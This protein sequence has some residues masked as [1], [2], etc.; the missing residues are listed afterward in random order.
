ME[1]SIYRDRVHR[2][3]QESAGEASIEEGSRT[4]CPASC[5]LPIG[6]RRQLSAAEQAPPPPR[7]P[8]PRRPLRAL[9]TAYALDP[10][11]CTP[12]LRPLHTLPAVCS[13]QSAPC[14]PP[15]CPPRTLRAVVRMQSTT[16]AAA[17]ATPEA[18]RTT[19]VRTRVEVRTRVVKRTSTPVPPH[20]LG[21]DL[22]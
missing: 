21:R 10:A 15:R 6:S 12:P 22:G 18:A 2:G 7:P 1:I 19:V 11:P 3:S 17:W 5:T 9:P 4:L 13:L 8:A 20:R 16:A 14:T